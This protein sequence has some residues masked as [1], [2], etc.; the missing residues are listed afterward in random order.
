MVSGTRRGRRVEVS[1]LAGIERV[2]PRWRL[3]RR[4]R[5]HHEA[6]R[7]FQRGRR[8][9]VVVPPTPES[10]DLATALRDR[11]TSIVPTSA[12]HGNSA[13]RRQRALLHR[14]RRSRTAASDA[15]QNVRR[16]RRRHIC[17]AS[18]R[19]R[20]TAR[21]RSDLHY[22]VIGIILCLLSVGLI[23]LG[24]NVQR[25]RVVAQRRRCAIWGGG[26]GIYLAGLGLY[27]PAIILAPATLWTAMLAT[28]VV[29]NAC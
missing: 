15:P 9:E 14:R 4:G 25:R 26:W 10:I 23:T 24:T 21:A 18:A 22:I 6:H 16:R 7:S 5:Q 8:D 27:N 1:I 2:V 20:P 19:R 28:V 29:W 3:A 13:A 11:R 12:L 17:A